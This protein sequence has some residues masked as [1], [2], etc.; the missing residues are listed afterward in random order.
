V[1]A[2]YKQSEDS[3]IRVGCSGGS[4]G[5]LGN[6]CGGTSWGLGAVHTI[7]SAKVDIYA[8]YRFFELDDSGAFSVEDISVF[9][10]GSRIKFD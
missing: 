4:A 8:G 2:D 5:V 7:P 10:V 3:V 1:A 9:F 6:G